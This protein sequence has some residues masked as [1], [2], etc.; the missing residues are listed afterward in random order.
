[1]G[2]AA[3][4]CD[5]AMDLG[6]AADGAETRVP[7]AIT[8]MLAAELARPGDASDLDGTDAICEVQRLR[9][10]MYENVEARRELARRRST[11]SVRIVYEQYNDLFDIKDGK[12]S[13]ETIDEEYCLSDVMPG[14]IIQLGRMPERERHEREAKG[15][16]VSFAERSGGEFVGLY[17]YE[18]TPRSYYCVVFQDAKQRE[19]DMIA[20]K[21]RMESAFGD[22]ATTKS[23]T[24]GCSC[25]EGNPCTEANKYNCKNWQNRFAV[26]REHGWKGF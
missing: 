18:D 10:L 9:R 23:R 14:C 24:E 12:I 21:K 4:T 6:A 16:S 25:L 2:A 3:T 13:V 7:A 26:A 1:M 19:A 22:A 8:G 11:G 20:T 5:T 15:E 17:T